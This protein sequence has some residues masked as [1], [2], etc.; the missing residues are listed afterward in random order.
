MNKSLAIPE[1]KPIKSCGLALERVVL[2]YRSLR[3]VVSG[4][5]SPAAANAG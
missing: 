5:H 3:Q 4:T 2:Q 1:A